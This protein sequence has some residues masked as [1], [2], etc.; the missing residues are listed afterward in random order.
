MYNKFAPR[1]CWYFK[2]TNIGIDFAI[3]KWFTYGL[4]F[5]WLTEKKKKNL[6]GV[7]TLGD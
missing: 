7:I 4:F 1:C 2:V 3:K 6:F 5:N